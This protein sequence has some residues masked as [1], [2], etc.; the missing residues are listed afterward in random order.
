LAVILFKT[1]QYYIA[2]SLALLP[3]LITPVVTLAGVG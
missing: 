1:G 2:G 3:A